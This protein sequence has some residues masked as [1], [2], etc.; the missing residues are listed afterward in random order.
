MTLMMNDG[1]RPSML[2]LDR[3][4]A[5]ELDDAAANEV[6]A[7]M[8]EAGAAHFDAV[9]RAR[10]RVAPFD[11]EILRKRAARLDEQPV[12]TEPVRER[13][14]FWML[15]APLAL[16][17]L[18][19]LFVSRIPLGG[20]TVRI[21][22]TAELAPYHLEEGVLVP[23]DGRALGK[24]DV[25]GFRVDA[26]HGDSVVV[27]SVDGTGAVSQFWPES[28]Q[29]PEPVPTATKVP[30]PGSITLDDAPGPEV[31]VADFS[32]RPVDEVRRRVQRIHADGGLEALR[33]WAA[34]RADVDVTVV[35][36]R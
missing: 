15:L 26:R 6:R 36:R 11:P 21:K 35:E 17:M 1:D 5:G 32:G 8:G 28:G 27:L 20:D 23:Y 34:T 7:R 29:A 30:L 31:F 33:A 25:L 19:L 9:T 13:R 18:A 3:L 14:P 12:R 10:E 4:A 16:A 2:D 24:G 22:G